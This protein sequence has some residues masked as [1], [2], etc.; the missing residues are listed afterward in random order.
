MERLIIKHGHVID[1]A[2]GLD[3]LYNIYIM[4]GRIASV[5]PAASDTTEASP[6]VEVLDCSGKII[7]PGF[8]DVHAHLRE[9]GYEYK[10]TLQTGGEAAAAGGYTTV[11]CM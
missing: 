8:I 9:P 11:F 6:G 4:S 2:S 3:G 10:E 1:P 7:V 5:K